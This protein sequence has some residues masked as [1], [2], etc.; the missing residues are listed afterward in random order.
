[1]RANATDID[2]GG[3]CVC[4]DLERVAA[5]SEKNQAE[6]K[7]IGENARRFAERVLSR[8][9]VESY[10]LAVLLQVAELEKRAGYDIGKVVRELHKSKDPSASGLPS[11]SLVFSSPIR[12]A[13][14]VIDRFKVI[15]D[16]MNHTESWARREGPLAAAAAS[17]DGAS[18]PK[19]SCPRCCGREELRMNPNKIVRSTCAKKS[20]QIRPPDELCVAKSTRTSPAGSP[21][22][23]C[24]E[25]PWQRERMRSIDTEAASARETTASPDP[26]RASS[27]VVP[28]WKRWQLRHTGQSGTPTHTAKEKKETKMNS[29]RQHS[30]QWRVREAE[31]APG[32]LHGTSR[33]PHGA[34]LAKGSW[35]KRIK[36]HRSSEVGSIMGSRISDMFQGLGHPGNE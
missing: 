30:P 29:R 32:H 27:G 23:L 26:R 12:S 18:C 1:M 16:A 21:D 2:D 3:S 15:D 4:A 36:E 25:D 24:S 34:G 7:R 14:D 9:A 28:P 22:H 17:L 33:D 35:S 13:N 5:W 8:K 20:Q 10:V 11:G 19:S 6:A 31:I